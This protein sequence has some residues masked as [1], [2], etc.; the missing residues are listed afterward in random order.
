MSEMHLIMNGWRGYLLQEHKNQMLF[1]DTEYITR[2]LGISLPLTEA[3]TPAPL[4]ENLK[5]QILHEQLILESFWED[6]VQNVKDAAGAV[7]GK[8]IDAAEGIKKFGKQGWHVIK[9]LY[10]VSTN[11]NLIPNFTGAIWKVNL[12]GRWNK[13][14]RPILEDLVERL[15]E[16]GMPTFA[17]AAQ[18]VLGMIT[19]LVDSVKAMSGWKKAIATGGLAIGFT[20]MWDKVKDFVEAYKV[21]NKKLQSADESVVEQFK[22]WLKGALN[23]NFLNILKSQFTTLITKLI[24]VATGV[25]A[26]WDA[27]ASAVGGTQL[28]INALSAPLSRFARYTGQGKK[29]N[30]SKLNTAST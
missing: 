29:I 18:K 28:V 11:P 16:W 27:A 21:W 15:P 1:E 20:W 13:G 5:K 9:Q 17:T 26:W 7:A 3:G 23:S 6:A 12:K 19:K 22:A 24:S 4:T 14:L 30:F 10:R 8:F 2:V 25:K